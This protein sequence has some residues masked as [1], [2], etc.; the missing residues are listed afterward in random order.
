MESAIRE[1][2]TSGRER[3]NK[4]SE[5]CVKHCR[6]MRM[7]G[8]G[9][10]HWFSFD[11]EQVWHRCNAPDQ[12]WTATEARAGGACQVEKERH[13]SEIK[14]TENISQSSCSFK[15]WSFARRPGIA[16]SELRPMAD[17]PLN[18]MR[19]AA[20]PTLIFRQNLQAKAKVKRTPS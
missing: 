8:P 19:L 3:L 18:S 15:A 12:R 16:G 10:E 5:C 14:S 17:I 1:M 6:R 9:T 20:R 11:T 2:R 7:E 13:R 4:H